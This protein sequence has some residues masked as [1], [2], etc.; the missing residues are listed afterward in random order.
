ME[1]KLAQLLYTCHFAKYI[2]RSQQPCR[3]Q[4]EIEPLFGDKRPRVAVRAV[5][6]LLVNDEL[7]VPG[8]RPCLVIRIIVARRPCLEIE[9]V[10]ENVIL[11]WL[12]VSLEAE[13]LPQY[14]ASAGRGEPG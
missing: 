1:N 14:R 11:W 12:V 10:V 7:C 9:A 6:V 8:P 13:S 3:A 5:W 2:A 4:V